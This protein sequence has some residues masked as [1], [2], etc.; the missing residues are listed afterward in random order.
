MKALEVSEHA[1]VRNESIRKTGADRGRGRQTV[2]AA[3]AVVVESGAELVRVGQ[4]IDRATLHTRIVLVVCK[5]T[6]NCTHGA[7]FSS[8][9]AGR[10]DQ[11]P[12]RRWG[13]V[14]AGEVAAEMD[15][16]LALILEV[17]LNVIEDLFASL[18]SLDVCVLF[19]GHGESP[20][21]W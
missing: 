20:S 21:L 5:Q 10:V 7:T 15:R 13:A 17:R 1:A 12:E 3:V 14:E 19:G 11:Q 6:S 8:I 2:D 18:K 4:L 16:P 9:G